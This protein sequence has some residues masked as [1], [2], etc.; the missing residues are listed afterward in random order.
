M[1]PSLKPLD[2][3]VLRASRL[4]NSQREHEGPQPFP[5]PCPMRVFPVVV[6]EVYPL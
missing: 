1:E 5:I 3:G 2:Y 6:P 4:M